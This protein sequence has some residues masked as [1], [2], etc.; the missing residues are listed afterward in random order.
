MAVPARAATLTVCASG[1]TYA[2]IQPA[3]DAAQFGD[4]ILLRAGQTFVGHYK[5]RAKIG[6]GWIT[7]RGDASGSLLPPDGTRL[8]PAGRPGANTSLSLLP[9]IVGRGGQYKTTPLLRTDPGAHGYRIQY[10]DFDGIAQ[11][12][13]ETLIMLGDDTTAARPYDLALEHV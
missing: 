10:V 8:I 13:Y 7:I 9:R 11:V 2:D 3:I 12:G 5:L 1:C 6:T 4:T